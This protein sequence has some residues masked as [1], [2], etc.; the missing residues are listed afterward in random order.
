MDFN[1]N[2]KEQKLQKS[3]PLFEI[4]SQILAPNNR[5]LVALALI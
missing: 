5:T 3:R 4:L 2:F 1:K